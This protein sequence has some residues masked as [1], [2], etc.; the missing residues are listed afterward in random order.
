MAISIQ[1]HLSQ[2]AENLLCL[3][4]DSIRRLKS[5]ARL[6]EVHCID[7]NRT[8]DI[9]TAPKREVAES[10]RRRL[11]KTKSIGRKYQEL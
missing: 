10:N 4:A 1:Y 5:D 8:F 3:I 7:R 6:K 9:Y 11:T 2:P